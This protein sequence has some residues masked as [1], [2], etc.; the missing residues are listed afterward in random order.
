LQEKK[1]REKAIAS[2]K[3]NKIFILAGL[4]FVKYKN[5]F[6]ERIGN[7]KPPSKMKVVFY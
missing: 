5:F 1:I 3:V 4:D 2:D 6:P 7:K